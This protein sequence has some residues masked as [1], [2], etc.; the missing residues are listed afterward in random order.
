MDGNQFVLLTCLLGQ[1]ENYN[2]M[3]IPP[4]KGEIL[5][6]C[7][8]LKCGHVQKV[9]Q[10][11]QKIRGQVLRIHC[12]IHTSRGMYKHTNPSVTRRTESHDQAKVT[13]G[14]G[15][16]FFRTAHR[17]DTCI[18]KANY[19][20]RSFWHWEILFVKHWDLRFYIIVNHLLQ[21]IFLFVLLKFHS[22]T[23]HLYDTSEEI[24]TTGLSHKKICWDF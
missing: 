9:L 3:I 12:V 16:D 21:K 6:M 7:E 17:M 23:V 5:L 22:D 4:I 24:H 18:K 10:M 1:I 11:P 15:A 19:F 2:T 14:N 20:Q 13:K 8:I